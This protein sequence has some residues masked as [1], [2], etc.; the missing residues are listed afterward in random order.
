LQYY[1]QS[2]K[3]IAICLV[4]MF[5]A[6]G[7]LASAAAAYVTYRFKTCGPQL[8]HEELSDVSGLDF[9]INET[10]CIPALLP[11]TAIEVSVSDPHDRNDRYP[12][13]VLE[14]VPNRGD[15][16]PSIAVSGDTITISAPAMR[17]KFRMNY[18]RDKVVKYEVGKS[19]S[20]AAPPGK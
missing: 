13:T 12:N 17:Q 9:E 14:Y 16:L 15:P 8:R 5:A 19:V 18:W 11:D 6:I 10:S 2:A 7:V 20:A 4:G 1:R 3:F